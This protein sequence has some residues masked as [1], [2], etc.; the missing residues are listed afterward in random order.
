MKTTISVLI[1]SL[2]ALVIISF[3]G[4]LGEV[5]KDREGNM[6]KIVKIGDQVWMAENLNVSTFRN[7]DSISEAQSIKDWV[8][9]GSK[10]QPAWCYYQNDPENG[11]KYGKLYNWYVVN[12]PRGLAPE[13]WHVPTDAEWQKLIDYLGGGSVAG[14]KMK[15]TTNWSSPN[16]GATNESGFSALPSGSRDFGGG[17]YN[18]AGSSAYFWSSTEIIRD[19]AWHWNLDYFNAGAYLHNINERYGFS[20]RCVKD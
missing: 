11:K 12:D 20:V 16:T 3:G 1:L 4:S 7:G 8:V 2:L 5:I 10:R 9:L 6:Y 15:D 14:G 17:S 13:G 18:N 19:Y